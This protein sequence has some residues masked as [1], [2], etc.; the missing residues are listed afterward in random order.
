MR[1]GRMATS[2]VDDYLEATLAGH[3]RAGSNGKASL[4][5]SR[6]VVHA[7][8]G[9]DLK[10][11]KQSVVNHCLSALAMLLIRL[12]DEVDRAVEGA[13]ARQVAGGAE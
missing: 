1:H 13:V 10:T 5:Q 11:Q 12:K 3:D 7:I 9:V 8:Y 2:A 4:R 6:Q